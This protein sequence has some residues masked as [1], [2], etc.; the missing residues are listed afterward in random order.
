MPNLRLIAR[1]LFITALA[2]AP[3]KPGAAQDVRPFTLNHVGCVVDQAAVDAAFAS[4][5]LGS[6]FAHVRP[7]GGRNGSIALILG[8]L[9]YIELIPPGV[10]D[11]LG[12][13][14]KD[15]FLALHSEEPGG[16]EWLAHRMEAEH[17]E[18]SPQM[19]LRE[20]VGDTERAPWY[21]RVGFDYEGGTSRFGVW[22]ME[23]H[24]E[25]KH[26]MAPEVNPEPGDISR[27]R[28]AAELAFHEDKLFWNVVGLEVG[29]SAAR[30]SA[31]ADLFGVLGFRGEKRDTG[32]VWSGRGFRIEVQRAVNADE[33]ALRKLYLNLTRAPEGQFQEELGSSVALL[34]EQG[35]EAVLE[36]GRRSN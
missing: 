2:T 36:F 18:S 26:H 1:T 21:Y 30:Q 27:R 5:F 12:V 16:I 33:Y 3:G 11:Q 19:H 22:A 13:A 10:A 34:L 14:Q 24:P 31:L 20:W 29:V 15:C 23:Y 28:P 6:E 32:W 25:F 7:G 17:P 4:E 35:T 8:E 9:T